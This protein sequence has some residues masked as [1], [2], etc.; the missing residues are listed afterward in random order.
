MQFAELPLPESVRKGIAEA[1][2][3]ECTP[4]RH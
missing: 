1:G 4:I 3:T 2:F